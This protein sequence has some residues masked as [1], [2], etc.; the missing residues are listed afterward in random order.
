[1][2]DIAACKDILHQVIKNNRDFAPAYPLP[3]GVYA[4]EKNPGMVRSVTK[5]YNKAKKSRGISMKL[6]L[7]SWG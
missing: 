5:K 1:M 2:D 3:I 7:Y 6:K 4:E